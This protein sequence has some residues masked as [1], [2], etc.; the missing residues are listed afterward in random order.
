M[1]NPATLRYV[2]DVALPYATDHGIELHELRKVR[3][4]GTVETMHGRLLQPGSRSLPIPVRTP[5]TR[6]QEL[7][8][9]RGQVWRTP[10]WMRREPCA[11]AFAGL[12]LAS[13]NGDRRWPG[14]ASPCQ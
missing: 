2:H 10:S 11:T 14:A 1:A 9:G 4:D 3:R 6:V 12:A 8:T 5:E 7:V 13:T